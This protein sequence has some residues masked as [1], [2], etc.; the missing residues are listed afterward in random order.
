M[1][2]LYIK[3]YTL[4]RSTYLQ[5]VFFFIMFL[6]ISKEFFIWAAFD[7]INLSLWNKLATMQHIRILLITKKYIIIGL[8]IKM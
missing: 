1:Y 7:C 6:L 8:D 2:K 5:S 3:K 4:S